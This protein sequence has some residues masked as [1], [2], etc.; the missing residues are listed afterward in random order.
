[1]CVLDQEALLGRIPYQLMRFGEGFLSQSVWMS[2]WLNRLPNQETKIDAQIREI[3]KIR[4]QIREIVAGEE[5]IGA[6]EGRIGEDG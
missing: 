2:F 1:M 3:L 5:Q 4:A 6:G